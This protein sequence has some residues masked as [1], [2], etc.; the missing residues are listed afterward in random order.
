MTETI[1][2]IEALNQ[3]HRVTCRVLRELPAD[4]SQRQLGVLLTVYLTPPPHTIRSLSAGLGI[5]K[6][7]LCRAVDA[8]AILD[9]LR[10][11]KD[12]DD[13]RTVFLQRTVQGA[14]FLNDFSEIL[15]GEIESQ[16]R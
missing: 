1:T 14:V 6:P 7:A 5:S 9:F 15:Q 4:L 11:A 10:R 16:G 12:P 8:L 3:W 13:R 2:R